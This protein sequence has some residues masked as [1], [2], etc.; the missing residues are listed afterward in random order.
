MSKKSEVLYE[1]GKI[2]SKFKRVKTGKCEG[3]ERAFLV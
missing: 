1:T 3:M 2:S